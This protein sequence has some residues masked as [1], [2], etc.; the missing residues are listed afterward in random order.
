MLQ[1][2]RLTLEK[3]IAI[4]LCSR[5]GSWLQDSATQTKM[6]EEQCLFKMFFCFS[7]SGGHKKAK[8]L[9]VVRALKNEEIETGMT[10]SQHVQN[11]TASRTYVRN[12]FT[13]IFN[14]CSFFF[15]VESYL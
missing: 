14:S 1:K 8:Y 12:T 15:G 9:S 2:E 3:L 5:V 6:A 10:A 4:W 7:K 13:V 11:P